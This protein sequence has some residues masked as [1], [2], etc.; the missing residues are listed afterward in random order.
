M[1]ALWNSPDAQMQSRSVLSDMRVSMVVILAK[2]ETHNDEQPP[3]EAASRRHWTIQVDSPDRPLDEE[4]AAL[5][6]LV[7]DC[8]LT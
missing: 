1:A 6:V 8:A 3:V 2:E 4:E 5:L 7:L